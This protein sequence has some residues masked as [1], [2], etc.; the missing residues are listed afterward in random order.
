MD[1]RKEMVRSIY[2]AGGVTLLPGFAER[3]QAEMDKLTP[4]S[5]TPKVSALSDTVAVFI[6]T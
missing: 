4:P 1:I 5:V 3:L 2:L 6:Y